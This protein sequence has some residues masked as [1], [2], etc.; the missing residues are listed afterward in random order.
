MSHE[1]KPTGSVALAPLASVTPTATPA[2]ALPA[3]VEPPKD[4]A[5]TARPAALVASMPSYPT[6]I[7]DGIDVFDVDTP[8]SSAIT[9]SVTDS[10]P[11]APSSAS[12][13]RLVDLITQISVGQLGGHVLSSCLRFSEGRALAAVGDPRLR[14]VVVS[15]TRWPLSATH[16]P[17]RIVFS[18]SNG[19]V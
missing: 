4:N 11:E 16:I 6:S 7:L 17:V 3:P 10:P 15:F 5:K 18:S 1:I 9:V 8:Q 2:F 12:A 19:H 13:D 14:Q